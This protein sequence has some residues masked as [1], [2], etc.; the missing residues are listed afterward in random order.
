MRKDFDLDFWKVQPT[1]DMNPIFWQDVPLGVNN[2]MLRYT[3]HYRLDDRPVGLVNVVKYSGNNFGA[4]F[5]LGQNL[6]PTDPGTRYNVRPHF[7]EGATWIT[8]EFVGDNYMRIKEFGTPII[9][10][11][12]YTYTEPK[13]VLL[14]VGDTHKLGD[15]TLTVTDIQPDMGTVSVQFTDKDG[16]TEYKVLG[17]LNDEARALLPQHQD[18]VNT[19]QFVTGPLNARVM[20]EMDTDKPYEDGTAAICTFVYIH[21][22]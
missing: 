7:G 21:K 3:N 19:L 14:G 15:Y 2:K 6:D 11:V 9:K 12:Q 20:A 5:L 13:R 22:F 18:V 17:P 4:P 1:G 10:S 8:P 16:K